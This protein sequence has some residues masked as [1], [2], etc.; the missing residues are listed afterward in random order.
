MTKTIVRGTYS[1]TRTTKEK[2]YMIFKVW[3]TE[4][5]NPCHFFALSSN[6]HKEVVITDITT[7]DIRTAHWDWMPY[8]FTLET[9]AKFITGENN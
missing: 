6:S 4:W 1:I 3:N 7:G 5:D 8:A 9:C 2:D